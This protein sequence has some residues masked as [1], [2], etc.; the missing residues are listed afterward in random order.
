M[1]KT[2]VELE[3]APVEVYALRQFDAFVPFLLLSRWMCDKFDSYC[4]H[5]YDRDAPL[6]RTKEEAHDEKK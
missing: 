3:D 4:C 2:E 5:W 1:K 6:L